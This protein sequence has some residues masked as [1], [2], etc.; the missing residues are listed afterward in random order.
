MEV[1]GFVRALLQRKA[2]LGVLLVL[3][4]LA[5]FLTAFRITPGGVE[6]RSVAVGAATGQILVD[7][8][9]STLVEGAGSDQIAALGTRARVYAQYL[10]SRDAVNKIA[11]EVNVDPAFITAAGPFSEGTGIGDYDQQGAESR[12]RDLVD[13]GMQYRLVFAAQEDVPIIT[14]YSTGPDTGQALA[15]AKS[16]FKVLER[17]I[18]ELKVDA[19]RAEVVAPPQVD[20]QAASSVPLVEN[21]V[22]RELGAPEGGLV[23]GK[24]DYVLMILAFLSVFGLGCLVTAAAS[25]FMRHWR[26]AGDMEKV[27]AE[28]G[29]WLQEKD[30]TPRSGPENGT[31]GAKETAGKAG[32]SEP[33]PAVSATQLRRREEK[34][35]SGTAAAGP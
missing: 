26:L 2:V 11:R 23:G 24:A 3:A 20:P 1:V 18:D 16:S 4:V 8:A 10:S 19:H 28:A 34:R 14:V 33:A 21:I 29:D 35:R 7:S 31:G 27:G 5:A 17:Y 12:A 13:E 15:L 30:A 25:G 32:R 6:R 9:E 22:V